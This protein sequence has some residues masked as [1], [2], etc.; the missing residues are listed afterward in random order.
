MVDADLITKFQEICTRAKLAQQKVEDASR[1]ESG[2]DAAATH[3]NASEATD[4]DAK[5]HTV[6]DAAPEAWQ[7]IGDGLRSPRA[8]VRKHVKKTRSELGFS[9]VDG[10]AHRVGFDPYAGIDRGDGG[11]RALYLE[12]ADA[13]GCMDDLA[14]QIGQ[15]DPVG[16]GDADRANPGSRKVEQQR[17]AEATRADYEHARG[18][19]LDLA[20]F[21]DLVEDQ[22]AG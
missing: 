9:V 1:D 4:H 8:K 14:L 15:V 13:V 5:G 22:M 2:S 16:V 7:D 10:E 3:A 21:A 12:R 6:Q 17:R 18:E 11:A 20:S 19:Q